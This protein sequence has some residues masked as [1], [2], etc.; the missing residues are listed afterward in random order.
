MECIDSAIA[1]FIRSFERNNSSGNW[2]QVVPQFAEVF[3]V[4]TPNGVQCVRSVD[5][6]TALPKR[7]QLFEQLGWQSTELIGLQESWLDPRYALVTTRW[8]FNFRFTAH[9]SGPVEVSSTFLIDTGKE[10]FQIILYLTQQDIMQ[11]MKE[12]GVVGNT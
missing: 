2:S 10:R 3:L 9:E 8:R 6:A 12:R 1:H 5:F 11:V 7:R 4:V